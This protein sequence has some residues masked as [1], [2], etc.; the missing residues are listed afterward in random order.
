MTHCSANTSSQGWA[1]APANSQA[2]RTDTESLASQPRRQSPINSFRNL[3]PHI[4]SWRFAYPAR[5]PPAIGTPFQKRT[6][7]DCT[8]LPQSSRLRRAC[9]QQK[10]QQLQ[11]RAYAV[12]FSQRSC[13][14]PPSLR[15]FL[16]LH[17]RKNGSAVLSDFKRVNLFFTLAMPSKRLFANNT[18]RK[19]A[20]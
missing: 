13:A 2:T 12:H 11:S 14:F 18:P 10:C 6:P 16:C 17:Y 3:A 7:P 1:I 4:N 15:R 19:K 8:S 5:L 9:I 20:P